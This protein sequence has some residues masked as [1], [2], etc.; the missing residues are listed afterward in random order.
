[1][2]SYIV[3]RVYYIILIL[4]SF[5]NIILFNILDINNSPTKLNAY[6]DIIEYYQ[7]PHRTD[8]ISNIFTDYEIKIENSVIKILVISFCIEAVILTIGCLITCK[9]DNSEQSQICYLYLCSIILIASKIVIMIFI[10]KL[11][12]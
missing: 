2:G 11:R 7:I 1:M 12:H 3:L 9:K 10:L 8:V 6:K 4:F 5:I